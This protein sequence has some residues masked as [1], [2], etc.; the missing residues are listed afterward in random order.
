MA[1]GYRAS[2][3]PD[4]TWNIHDVPVFASNKL[5][6]VEVTRDWQERA[7]AKAQ[8]R[9]RAVGHIPPLHENHTG[10]SAK[11]RNLGFM[12]PTRV[13]TLKTV[14]EDEAGN[15]VTR[16]AAATYADFQRI[17]DADYQ[18][19][20][21]GEL[22]YVSVEAGLSDHELHSAALL[23]NAPAIKTP[24]IA[25]ASEEAATLVAAY[26]AEGGT[27]RTTMRF[28]ATMDESKQPKLDGSPA[29]AALA[30]PAEKP[31]TENADK[32]EKPEAA[33]PDAPATEK[34]A[35]PGLD[36]AALFGQVA[37]LQQQVAALVAAAQKAPAPEQPAQPT[38]A[39][40]PSPTPYA[41]VVEPVK[42]PDAQPATVTTPATPAQS[43]PETS[44]FAAITPEQFGALVA[45]V[46]ILK[47]E[48]VAARAEAAAAKVANERDAKV[49]GIVAALAADGF[50]VPPDAEASLSQMAVEKGLPAVEAYATGWRKHGRKVPPSSIEG[51][52]EAPAH[53]ELTKA[54]EKYGPAVEPHVARFSAA[55]DEL[56]GASRLDRETFVLRNLQSLRLIKE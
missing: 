2:K 26:S 25:I 22:P 54:F 16:D 51:A 24:P 15:L 48:A 18:R 7:V 36:V 40:A 34:P 32:A 8:E 19:I 46:D 52:I 35:M 11:V 17:P 27:V 28:A 5:R 42:A 37:M 43:V 30:P 31:A 12:V 6:K 21:R 56:K 1:P 47:A 53:P 33:A 9:F 50:A 20:K 29:D 38:G 49:R 44:T 23:P 10:G 41:A 39:T 45:Q 3:N 4:G 14:E 55:F 13:G